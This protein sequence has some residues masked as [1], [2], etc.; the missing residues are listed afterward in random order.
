MTLMPYKTNT[1]M[2][3]MT[4]SFFMLLNL[5]IGITDAFSAA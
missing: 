2:Q 3:E 1:A 4:R 5:D